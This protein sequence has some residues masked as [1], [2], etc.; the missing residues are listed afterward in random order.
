MAGFF[1]FF[2][3]T[4]PGKGVE[5][6][7]F[8]PNLKT[9]FRVFFER[10]WKL[11]Q[12]NVIYFIFSL[13]LIAV[14]FAFVPTGQDEDKLIGIYKVCVGG[15]LYL[16]II[17]LAPVITGFTYVLRNF[18]SDRHAWVLSDFFE[19]IKKNFKQAML[20][21][22]ID[23]A[24]S[25][26]IPFVYNFYSAVITAPA[27]VANP[28]LQ[29]ASFIARTII[30]LFASIYFIMHFYI[31]NIMI[32]FNLTVKQ[33]LKNSLIFALAHLPRNIG[34][35]ALAALIAMLTFGYNIEIGI[36]LSFLITPALIG[37]TV[38]FIIQPVIKKHMIK[39]QDDSA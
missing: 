32:T 11:I 24:V 17:G 8:K 36:L 21:F 27:E 38:N 25:L 16:S 2:D 34:V 15:L 9:F 13:P 31:Y 10:F 6:E 12:L 22:L 18:T 29:N 33:I 5:K 35:L 23:L 1:G 3:Y 14:I 26:I 7:E 39:T 37:Y 20:V 4:K 28:L 19:H 30:V